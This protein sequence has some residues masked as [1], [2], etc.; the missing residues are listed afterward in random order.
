MCLLNLT[1]GSLILEPA[2]LIVVA[3]T[4]VDGI[5]LPDE[6][7]GA[8]GIEAV[9]PGVG[10]LT[11]ILSRRGWDGIRHVAMKDERSNS[12]PKEDRYT[13]S[14]EDRKDMEGQEGSEV[15]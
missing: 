5:A 10:T 1:R 12:G 3:T 6:G 2:L 14:R 9:V 15:A 7:V 11:P 4:V 13:M 8:D